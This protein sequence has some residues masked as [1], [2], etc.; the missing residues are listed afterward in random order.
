MHCQTNYNGQATV[1]NSADFLLHDLREHARLVAAEQM[2]CIWYHVNG[3]FDNLLYIGAQG[4]SNISYNLT[5]SGSMT[6]YHM[7]LQYWPYWYVITYLAELVNEIITKK[8]ELQKKGFKKTNPRIG[9]KLHWMNERQKLQNKLRAKML[10]LVECTNSGSWVF[11]QKAPKFL[12]QDI[13]ARSWRFWHTNRKAQSVSSWIKWMYISHYYKFKMMSWFQIMNSP[14]RLL[15]GQYPEYEDVRQHCTMAAK[16]FY[17]ESYIDMW[18]ALA[19]RNKSVWLVSSFISSVAEINMTNISHLFESI[20]LGGYQCHSWFI[21]NP[22]QSNV[23][24]D[25]FPVL[26]EQVICLIGVLCLRSKFTEPW[27]LYAEWFGVQSQEISDSIKALAD[28]TNYNQCRD[29]K[30]VQPSKSKSICGKNIPWDVICGKNISWDKAIPCNLK[31][32][33]GICS[34]IHPLCTFDSTIFYRLHKS[35]NHK[36]RQYHVNMKVDRSCSF[37]RS[38]TVPLQGSQY[39]VH[40]YQIRNAVFKVFIF[41]AKQSTWMHWGLTISR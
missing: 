18:P 5:Y 17:L 31:Q 37:D 25:L 21:L 34:Q 6:I 40:W 8:Y 2:A 30:M 38:I 12:N 7:L 1:T 26:P 22:N 9:S 10:C 33:Y 16:W 23:A 11:C 19:K 4:I 39:T 13:Q 24:C 27:K 35:I 20:N 32:C 29:I 36:N 3:P 14:D 15:K 28:F 41:Y